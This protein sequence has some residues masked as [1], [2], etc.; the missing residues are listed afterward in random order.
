MTT[1]SYQTYFQSKLPELTQEYFEGFVDIE[2]PGVSKDSR[3][4]VKNHLWLSMLPW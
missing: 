1:L 3:E 4:F 2:Y